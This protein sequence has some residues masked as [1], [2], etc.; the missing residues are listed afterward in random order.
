MNLSYSCLHRMIL[1]QELDKFQVLLVSIDVYRDK[2]INFFPPT[3]D[4]TDKFF[5]LFLMYLFN[6]MKLIYL[7]KQRN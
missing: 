3:L 4:P 5:V 7:L 1:K 6:M 2:E